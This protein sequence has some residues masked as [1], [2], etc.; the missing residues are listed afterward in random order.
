MVTGTLAKAGYFMGDNLWD[1]REANPKGFFEDIEV[2]KLN[3]DIL[4]PIIPRRIYIR[5]ARRF[6]LPKKYLFQ[7]EPIRSQMWLSRIPINKPIKGNARIDDHIFALVNKSPYCFKD[8]RFS[9]T[10]PVWRPHLKNVVFVCV[11][12]DP[13]TTVRSILKECSSIEYLNHE[14][15][16]IRIQWK[17]A[18]KTW[19]L[20]Y[21][22]ILEKHRYSGNWLF[23]HYNQALTLEGLNKLEK[24]IQAPVD[25]EFPDSRIRRTFSTEPVPKRAKITYQKLCDLANYREEK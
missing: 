14:I 9:Y 22:H 11:F 20:M 5:G 10:L 17:H 2:N 4:E 6:N 16:G 19:T 3:E 15:R 23:M 12:R 8:P 7:H 13:A 25:K 1:A 24:F 21:Q 18:M